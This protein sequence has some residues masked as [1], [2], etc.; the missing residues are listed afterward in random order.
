MKRKGACTIIARKIMAVNGIG[1]RSRLVST[2]LESSQTIESSRWIPPKA[3]RF[4][5][6]WLE[7]PQISDAEN[8]V[9]QQLLEVA[10]AL[11]PTATNHRASERRRARCAW[12][13]QRPTFP[14]AA[15]HLCGKS[16]YSP[17]CYACW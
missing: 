14:A 8:D 6:K 13:G 15:T 7:E 4:A 16:A 10:A 9:F 17:L 12:D 2:V 1:R 5:C 3:F 11:E